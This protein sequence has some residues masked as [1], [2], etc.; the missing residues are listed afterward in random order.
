MKYVRLE[1]KKNEWRLVE[2]GTNK[3]VSRNP[4]KDKCMAFLL[5]STEYFYSPMR[6]D[7]HYAV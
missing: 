7:V 6:K 1:L 5:N 3:I 4:D 2:N